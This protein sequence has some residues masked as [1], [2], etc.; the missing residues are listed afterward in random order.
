MTEKASI[1]GQWSSRL[2]FIL[3]ATGSAV[4][5][6]NIWKFPY[7]A[8]E[9]GGGAFVLVYLLCIAVIGVPIMMAEILL[10]R[11]GRQSPINSMKS[12]AAEVGA[13]QRWA[14]L[15]WIGVVSGFL[16]MSFYSVIAGWALAYVLEAIS[17]NFSG[18]T[19]EGSANA[20]VG[21]ISNPGYTTFWHTVFSLMTAIVIAKGVKSGLEKAIR[22]LM[23]AL[24]VLL[25]MLLGYAI[26]SGHF[27]EGLNF[28]FNPD[29]AALTREG[30]LSALGH[31]FFTLSLGMG[32][33]MVYG[34][35][36]PKKTSIASAT[37]TVAFMDTLVAL[38]AG[39][40]IF[41]IVF[42][43]GLEPGA[44]PGLVFISLPI[45]FGQMSGGLFFGTLFFILLSFAAWTS[46]ISIVE[47]A[48]AFLV[49][50]RGMSRRKSTAIIIGLAWALGLLTVMSFGGWGF[51]FTFAGA[52]KTDGIFDIFDI[53][54]T[55]FMLPLG[56]LAIAL[57]TGW[58]MRSSDAA[59]ELK[60]KSPV[61]YNLWHFLLRFVSPLGVILFFLHTLGAF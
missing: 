38:V 54:T 60:M 18:L 4:G 42:A 33:I 31:A 26:N 30:V 58:V 40:A 23:P 20:F 29:F 17:G 59:D 35:Y 39:M 47:P 48:V 12:L 56:G 36:M 2:M 10:G 53:A 55:N 44:G 22:I 34:S 5:L 49:E 24:F 61:L 52:T 11:R 9:N 43:N 51:E 3:A 14:W 6:G 15:G 8:G 16:I 25:V 19:G 37:L 21:H 46:A 45:A 28:L 27:D 32:A 1:H 41:P 7:M 57:F 13:S 50:N